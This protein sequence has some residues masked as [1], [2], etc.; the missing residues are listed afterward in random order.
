LRW[1]ESRRGR[2]AFVSVIVYVIY[3]KRYSAS[4]ALAIAFTI[5]IFA[6]IRSDYVYEEVILSDGSRPWPII[7]NHGVFQFGQSAVHNPQHFQWLSIPDSWF[8]KNEKPENPAWFFYV[9]HNRTGWCIGIPLWFCLLVSVALLARSILVHRKF[10][11]GHC[12][13][14]GYDLR[15]TPDR[16]PECGT[17]SPKNLEAR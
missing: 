3:P 5:L 15:A 14:C 1:P 2:P 11:P 8:S 4:I 10:P 6:W 16:C 7:L 9:V 13:R 12:R 17:I